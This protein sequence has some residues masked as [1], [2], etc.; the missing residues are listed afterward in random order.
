MALPNSLSHQA[1]D[2][3]DVQK[4]L[5]SIV[6]GELGVRD[7]PE[8]R[9]ILAAHVAALDGRLA[10]DRVIDVLEGAGYGEPRPEP[11]RLRA[12]AA[13]AHLQG[14]TLVKRYNRRRRGH[15]NNLEFHRHRFPGVDAG[16]LREKIACFGR[17]LDRFDGLRVE[18]V[19]E[20]LFKISR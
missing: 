16:V 7:D 20:H 19:D 15:R 12:L 4:T 10:A 9:E 5:H 18:A 13:R 2:V 11:P 17:L 1:C 8:V 3:K 14:R 6:G